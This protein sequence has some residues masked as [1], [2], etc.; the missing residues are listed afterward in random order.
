MAKNIVKYNELSLIAIAAI[1]IGTK[2]FIIIS[3]LFIY[4]YYTNISFIKN[5]QNYLF[6]L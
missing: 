2:V 1:S 3:N 5:K 4:K 6:N